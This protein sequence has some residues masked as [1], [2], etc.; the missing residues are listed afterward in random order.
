MRIKIITDIINQPEVF[1]K[2]PNHTVQ[3]FL[4]QRLP[5]EMTKQTHAEKTFCFYTYSAPR[6]DKERNQLSFYFS[7]LDHIT[8]SLIESLENNM[9]AQFGP[10]LCRIAII[11]ELPEAN[12]ADN[13]LLL[14]GKALISRG[15]RTLITETAEME[16]FL[17]Y[18]AENKLK[19]LGLP[20]DVQFKVFQKESTHTYYRKGNNKNIN[21]P[22]WY[23]TVSVE[24]EPESLQALYQIGFGQ[25][26]GTGNGLFWEVG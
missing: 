24:G 12:P 4:L 16:R 3:A 2:L 17:G 8:K 21:L 25:N 22:G 13:R 23:I 26:T 10:Y 6:I 19:A 11:E 15:D 1:H 18:Y 9:L 20:S 14:K 5:I 7:S